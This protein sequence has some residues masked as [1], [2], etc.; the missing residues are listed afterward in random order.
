[1]HPVTLSAAAGG[2]VLGTLKRVAGASDD[3]VRP[4]RAVPLLLVLTWV[5]LAVL[6]LLE[7]TFMGGAVEVPFLR[8]PAVQTRLLI[9]LPLLL[10]GEAKVSRLAQMTL[11]LIRERR[12]VPE[13]EMPALDDRVA[14]LV[15]ERD[16]WPVDLVIIVGTVAAMWLAKGSIVAERMGAHTSWLGSGEVLSWAGWWYFMVS[17]VVVNVIGVRW[18]W[19]LLIW[20]RFLVGFL[21][22]RLVVSPG[23]PDLHGG[24]AFL[25][26]V[27]SGFAPVL[28]SLAATVS[29]RLGFELLYDG[30]T[31]E[32]VKVPAAVVMVL[33]VLV[34]FLPL[35][36]FSGRIL[37]LKRRALLQYDA[38]GQ[39]L[40]AGFEQKWLGAARTD[41]PL[42]DSSDP[43][44][45]T[46]YIAVYASLREMQPSPLDVRRALPALI[47]VAVPFLPLLL[48]ELSMKEIVLRMLKLVM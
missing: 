20:T 8:D 33:A 25:T 34:M 18:L 46:D 39:Q 32:V 19:W 14:Q 28:T 16:S 11:E 6:T 45:Y 22:P 17:G 3:T 23:H 9:A 30:A 13:P 29:G 47:M 48:T 21:R 27:Q 40:V 24:L 31:L 35:L 42:L 26:M 1:M 10:I 4:V 41:E 15:R 7:G 5:P 44:T 2:I 36:L 43:S 12:L 38:L 37:G